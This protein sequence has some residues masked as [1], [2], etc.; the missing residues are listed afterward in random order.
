MVT[1]IQVTGSTLTIDQINDAIMYAGLPESFVGITSY[2]EGRFCFEVHDSENYQDET[3][4]FRMDL[5]AR[6]SNKS[7]YDVFEVENEHY[8]MI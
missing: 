6:E 8:A 4:S 7:W 3:E 1:F 2:G 5:Q